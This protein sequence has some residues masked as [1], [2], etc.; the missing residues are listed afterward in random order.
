MENV[1][2]G[3][4][5]SMAAFEGR[6]EARRR[7]VGGI[8]GGDDAEGWRRRGGSFPPVKSLVGQREGQNGKEGPDAGQNTKVTA[9]K[10]CA[11]PIYGT[12]LG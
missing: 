7:G 8:G 1:A 10:K 4:G 3:C 12:W 6:N 2:K 11:M 5:G 9:K